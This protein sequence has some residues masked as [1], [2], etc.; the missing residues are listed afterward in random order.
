MCKTLVFDNISKHLEFLQKYSATIRD[1]FSTLFSVFVVKHGVS[2][3]I[4]YMDVPLD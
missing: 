3:L 1:V 2:C 4:Y